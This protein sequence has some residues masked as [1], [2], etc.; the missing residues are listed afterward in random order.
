MFRFIFCQPHKFPHHFHNN[1]S[2][3]ELTKSVNTISPLQISG[4][5]K[6]QIL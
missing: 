5:N 2:T 6:L 3:I 1:F 4:F